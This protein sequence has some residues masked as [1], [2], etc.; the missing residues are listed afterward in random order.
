VDALETGASTAAAGI[1]RKGERRNLDGAR[2]CR[3]RPA[4]TG[5]AV[6]AVQHGGAETPDT[7]GGGQTNRQQLGFPELGADERGHENQI[8][9]RRL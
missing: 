8:E 6:A 9:R 4:T 7:V 5:I 1:R 2:R 3:I